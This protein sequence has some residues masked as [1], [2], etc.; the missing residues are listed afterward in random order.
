MN[1]KTIQMNLFDY[2]MDS[3]KFT[4]K[5][6]TELVKEQRNIDVNN[7]SIRAR[8]YEGLDSGLFSRVSRGVY[9]VESQFKDETISCLLI[10]GNGRNLS[11]IADS[12]I[13]SIIT[14]HPYDLTKSLTGGNRK[15]ATYELFK[16]QEE[17]FK[18]KSRVLKNGAFCVEFLPEENEVNFEYLYN[19]KQ[20]AIKQGFK[21]FAKVPWTKGD[22]VAN[23]GRKSKN[24]EDVMI[25]SKGEPRA[26]KLN[27]KKNYE[28]ARINGFDITGLSSEQVKDLLQQNNLVVHYMKGTAGMLPKSFDYQ[29]RGKKEKI[30]EAE[31]PVELLE[32]II[33]Y[34]TLPFEVVLDQFAGS[35][36]LAIASANKKRSSI[37]IEK[38]ETMFNK[39]KENIEDNLVLDQDVNS[40]I[41][42]LELIGLDETINSHKLSLGKMKIMANNSIKLKKAL[43][44]AMKETDLDKQGLPRITENKIIKHKL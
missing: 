22:F 14:D 1:D 42:D 44:L 29:P 37:L 20:M 12:S 15:F 38:D 10:N 27:A 13:D 18:E 8:I 11:S 32:D 23:T 19:L 41:D 39:M 25:F 33:E 36:N 31:K 43:D 35:G 28:E 40:I 3:E 6:A 9:K 24:S 17:D 2:F 5:E 34:V 21:Y 26:L 30:M 4:I 7:E 16:Y